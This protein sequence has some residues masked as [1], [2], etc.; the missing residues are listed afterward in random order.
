M[1]RPTPAPCSRS[2]SSALYRSRLTARST[3]ARSQRAS[4]PQANRAQSE[5]RANRGGEPGQNRHQDHQLEQVSQQERPRGQP[6]RSGYVARED[7]E[8]RETAEM[9]EHETGEHAEQHASPLP[10]RGLTPP[11]PLLPRAWGDQWTHPPHP[12]L[13]DDEGTPRP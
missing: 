3:R 6:R 10:P 8:L 4:H 1:A 9:D 12:R 2:K 11:P 7:R 13:Q 5:A